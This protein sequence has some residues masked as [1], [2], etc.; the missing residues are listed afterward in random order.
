MGA[1]EVPR[2]F[3]VSIGSLIDLAIDWWRLNRWLSDSEADASM[4]VVRHVARRLGEFLKGHEI[5]IMDVTGRPYEAGLAV[6][7]VDMLNDECAPEGMGVIDETVTP[8][9]LWRGTVVKHGQ[10][11]TR[12]RTQ[13]T[14]HK[15]GRQ[16]KE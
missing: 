13:E 9:V 6:E 5:E 7:V 11:V 3:D 1:N 10:I 8:I 14:G 2:L 12:R 16:N 15:G 4:A